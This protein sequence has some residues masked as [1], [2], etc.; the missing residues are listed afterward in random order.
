MKNE[1]SGALETGKKGPQSL[2]HAALYPVAIDCPR[3][4]FFR[5]NHGRFCP[6]S[7]RKRCYGKGKTGPM[8][9][10]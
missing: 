6:L 8:H 1:Y 10:P 3:R 7:F 5:N 9:T 4:H 2:A